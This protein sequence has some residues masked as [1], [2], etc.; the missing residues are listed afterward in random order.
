[1]PDILILFIIGSMAI[2]FV[3]LGLAVVFAL[4]DYAVHKRIKAIR[5]MK[6]RQKIKSVGIY[7]EP[8]LGRRH[9]FFGKRG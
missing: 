5:S 8:R 6:F 4:D 1:M 7:Y 3:S 9:P 2:C